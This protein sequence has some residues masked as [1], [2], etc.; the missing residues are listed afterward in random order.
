MILFQSLH[1][2]A[3]NVF[4]RILQRIVIKFVY[5][6]D[7]DVDD[8]HWYTAKGIG[9]TWREDENIRFFGLV[10]MQCREYL[11]ELLSVLIRFLC[12]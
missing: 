1:W 5:T 6:T 10:V 8:A 11:V 9:Q 3:R 12:S 4:F 2:S 7:V